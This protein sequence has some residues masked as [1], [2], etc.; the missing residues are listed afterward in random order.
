MFGKQLRK[1]LARRAKKAREVK[2]ALSDADLETSAR[3][4]KNKLKSMSRADADLCIM[5]FT[6]ALDMFIGL[7]LILQVMTGKGGAFLGGCVLHY[8]FCTV[9]E[10]LDIFGKLH[11]GDDGDDSNKQRFGT[12]RWR[13]IH[14]YCECTEWWPQLSTA[15]DV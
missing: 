1:V 10:L 6:T 5:W 15:S 14:D 12:A 8:V 13:V 3:S 11:T 7:A 9:L 2:K 4:V